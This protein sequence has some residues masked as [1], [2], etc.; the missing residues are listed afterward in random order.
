MAQDQ[1]ENVSFG[2]NDFYHTRDWS[3]E[4]HQD[5]HRADLTWLN[6]EIHSISR[7][8]P[9]RKVVVFTHYCPTRDQ[10]VVD[11][12]AWEQPAILWVYDGS[13]RG[14]LL[15]EQSGTLWAFGHTHFNCDFRDSRTGKRVLSN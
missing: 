11:P 6:K 2:L 1:L 9:G 4:S 3:L 14:M 15:E 8:E 5:A 10:N 7:G 13:I 12:K